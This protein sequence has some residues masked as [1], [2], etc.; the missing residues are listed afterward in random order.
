MRCPKG[1]YQGGRQHTDIGDFYVVF[2]WRY[3]CFMLIEERC[4]K[5]VRIFRS[6]TIFICCFTWCLLSESFTQSFRLS[7]NWCPTYPGDLSNLVFRV[8]AFWKA[9]FNLMITPVRGGVG[10]TMVLLSRDTS[11]TRHILQSVSP[12]HV[13]Q[14]KLIPTPL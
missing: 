9:V 2:F 7:H 11:L 13:S 8:T 10:H 6:C 12:L 14:E 4:R 5:L 3:K 1:R